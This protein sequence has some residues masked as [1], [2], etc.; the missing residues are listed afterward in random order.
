MINDT[1]TV[2]EFI[3]ECF[4]NLPQG[5]IALKGLRNREGLTQSK[6]GEI[7][8]IQQTNISQME[9]GKRSIGKASAKK[10]AELFHSDYRIFL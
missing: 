4:G 3:Q 8:G 9:R 5:A 2:D 6:L 1:C 10:I 7:L